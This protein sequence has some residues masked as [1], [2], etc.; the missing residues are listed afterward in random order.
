[1][2]GRGSQSCLPCSHELI[3]IRFACSGDWSL[4][5]L[6]RNLISNQTKFCETEREI[7]CRRP[8]LP[9]GGQGSHAYELVF[10]RNRPGI[11]DSAVT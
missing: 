11:G 8:V 7:F 5:K 2:Y 3:S 1:M 4:V 6:L 10:R 9:Q